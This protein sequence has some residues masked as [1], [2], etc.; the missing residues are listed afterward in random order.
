MKKLLKSKVFENPPVLPLFPTFYHNECFPLVLLEA[1]EHGLPCIS[2]TE[3]G[4]P[5]IVDDG[6]TGFLVPK[7]DVAVLAD[8]IQFLLNDS[9]LRSNMG[10]AGREKFEKEFTLE[11]F[12]K[13]MVEILSNNVKC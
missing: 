12:E 2:T 5:G 10:K 4:I 11:V 8:K 3:G 9:V 1:M 6:K 7:H 13:R